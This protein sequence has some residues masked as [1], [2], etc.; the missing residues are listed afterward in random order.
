MLP[1][2]AIHLRGAQIVA[3]EAG[4]AGIERLAL[5]LWHSVSRFPNPGSSYVRARARG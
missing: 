5:P 2:T 3:Q 1:L 4:R